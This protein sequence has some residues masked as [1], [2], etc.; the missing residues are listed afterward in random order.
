MELK[1]TKLNEGTQRALGATWILRL[2]VDY[3]EYSIQNA[4]VT[5]HVQKLQITITLTLTLLTWRIWWAPNNASRWQMG[6]NSAF[7]GLTGN[8]NDEVVCVFN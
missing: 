1:R 4:S 8:L 3:Y 6:F 2:C 5:G 7:K